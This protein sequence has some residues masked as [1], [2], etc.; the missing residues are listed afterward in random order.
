[1][2]SFERDYI[3][4]IDKHLSA[5][6]TINTFY[7][8]TTMKAL[9]GIIRENPEEG[10]EICLWATH[11]HCLNDTAELIPGAI[12]QEQL[13]SMIFKNSKENEN[14]KKVID[15]MKDLYI[16]SLSQEKNSLPMWNAY[17]DKGNGVAIGL[18]RQKSIN[19]EDIVVKCCYGSISEYLERQNKLLPILLSIYLP[20]IVKDEAFAY[21]NEVRIVGYFKDAPTKYRDKNGLKIPYKEIF[22]PKEQLESITLGPC[23]STNENE[24]ILIDFLKSRGM[25]NVIIKK[26]KIP[27]RNI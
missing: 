15:R 7:H 12:I 5:P 4:F 21:E 8:Y 10:K 2:D 22:F 14:R 18:K 25:Q 13:L 9:D 19:F 27:Y 23:I 26:S 6:L 11:N 16:L 1:M 17:A 20:Q 24:E 3:N